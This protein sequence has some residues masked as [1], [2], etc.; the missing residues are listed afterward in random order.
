MFLLKRRP[1]PP[2]I[3]E[4]A[5]PPGPAGD[6]LQEIRSLNQ[7]LAREVDPDRAQNL[8]GRIEVLET[9]RRALL[10][11]E[12]NAERAAE[13]SAQA[14]RD[15]AARE[16]GRRARDYVTVDALR[17]R[18]RTLQNKMAAVDAQKAAI[19]RRMDLLSAEARAAHPNIEPSLIW[20]TSSGAVAR[21]ERDGL[22]HE[23][24]SAAQELG[25]LRRLDEP[26]EGAS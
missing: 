21:A 3:A 10:L 11:V 22:D 12:R 23:W 17:A 20:E 7:Q 26:G 24:Y 14:A 9:R 15:R 13:E 16:A 8:I 19:Q 1:G 4:E 6:I 5:I 18:I 2:Q 25:A